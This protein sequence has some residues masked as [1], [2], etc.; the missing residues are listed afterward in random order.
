MNSFWLAGESETATPTLLPPIAAL[1]VVAIEAMLLPAL[2]RA[3]DLRLLGEVFCAVL[4][5]T[6]HLLT[7]VLAG[8]CVALSSP[9]GKR[10]FK[11]SLWF[12][13]VSVAIWFSPLIVLTRRGLGWTAV[14]VSGM[15]VLLAQYLRYLQQFHAQQ[16]EEIPDTPEMHSN[17]LSFSFQVNSSLNAHLAWT[18]LAM[19]LQAGILALVVGASLAAI[20]LN[21]FGFFVL[22]W[23][24]G[25]TN[26]P[27]NASRLGSSSRR[28]LAAN[29]L[30]AVLCVILRFA[31]P[32]GQK[33]PHFSS[34]CNG[35]GSRRQK[36]SFRGDP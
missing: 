23:T 34:L 7:S 3:S 11:K 32:T 8:W 5:F 10:R 36:P 28:K 16:R 13:F 35:P 9:F 6:L 17:F 22:A 14:S 29:L 12:R 20:L 30:L 31:L 26:L 4:G 1:L 27:I 25:Q 21:C 19:D 24:Y 18:F 33:R 15:A 2:V